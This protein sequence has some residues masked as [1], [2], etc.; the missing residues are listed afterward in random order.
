MKKQKKLWYRKKA[1][2]K[3]H[4]AREEVP[5]NDRNVLIAL[6]FDDI[7]LAPRFFT[8]FYSEKDECWCE[9]ELTN[10]KMAIGNVCRGS[11]GQG[12]LY[13]I[14]SSFNVHWVDLTGV[15]EKWCEP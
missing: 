5:D 12:E 15:L 6:V 4:D 9:T 7:R 8:G 14:K 11:C 1:A 3:W 13:G 10:G 2:V